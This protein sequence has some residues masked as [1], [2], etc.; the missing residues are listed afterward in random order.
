MVSVNVPTWYI[1]QYAVVSKSMWHWFSTPCG[2]RNDLMLWW[3][4]VTL[5]NIGNERLIR[6]VC[7]VR[8]SH[9]PSTLRN[10]LETS[11]HQDL[12]AYTYF[13]HLNRNRKYKYIMIGRTILLYMF[14][15]RLLFIKT[16]QCIKISNSLY[17]IKRSAVDTFLGDG[18]Y[19]SPLYTFL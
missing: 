8:K 19:I 17:I 5:S 16:I 6:R 4:H 9:F 12:V 10:A 7:T 18:M 1:T 11:L 2:I 14:K 13:H 15:Y 3:S